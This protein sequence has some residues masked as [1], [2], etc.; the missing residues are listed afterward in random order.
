M[1][2]LDAHFEKFLTDIS[3]CFT[4]R[5]FEMWRDR[6]LLPF[7]LVTGDGPIVLENEAALRINFDLY[8]SAC[9]TMRL[10][11]VVRV[12][13][14]LEDCGDGTWHGTY[15]TRLISRSAMASAPYI[16]TARL[17]VVDGTLKMSS[18]LNARGHYDWTGKRDM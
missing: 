5:D 11:T 16:A 14:E 4:K 15:E 9:D 12:P 6:I 18:I 17:H 8:L 7:T 2:V 10:D 3:D 13:L 1:D